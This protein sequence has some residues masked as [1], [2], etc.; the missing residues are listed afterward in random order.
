[1]SAG[2]EQKWRRGVR[3]ID[4]A[5]IATEDAPQ[6]AGKPNEA[7]SSVERRDYLELAAGGLRMPV[8]A[9]LLLHEQPDPDTI[10]VDGRRLG[11][12]VEKAAR[13]FRT[14]LAV[15]LMDLTIEK[16]ALLE[17]LGV[18]ADAIG[19]Y[20]LTPDRA[21][22][23][24]AV[25]QGRMAT[26]RNRRLDATCGAIQYIARATSLVPIGMVIGPWSLVVKLLR[27]PITAL[28]MAGRGRTAGE[29]PQV[30]LLERTLE[31]ATRTILWSIERQLAAGARAM[32]VCEPAAST[33]Y[34]SPRQLA[35]GAK[36]LERFVLV[37]NRRIKQRLTEAGCELIFH[38]CGELTPEFIRTF[39]QLDPVILSLGSSRTLW[40]DAAL[41]SKS[42]VLYG[43]LPTKSF[44]SDEVCPVARVEAMARELVGRMRATGHPFILGSECDVLSVPGAHETIRRKVDAFMNV[45]VE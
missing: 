15:P 39:V 24:L 6:I 2:G 36:L 17:M 23:R 41:V 9:H 13:T 44:Y 20:H 18:P 37:P 27:D 28:Y 42:I 22:E 4:A 25:V 12:V 30:A 35:A 10:I 11:Q 34:I 3:V 16:T 29:N 40:E 7:R 45:Q 8:G 43:N 38:C 32:F 1:M 21:D 14:P 33:A 26:H 5:S 19:T 31:L